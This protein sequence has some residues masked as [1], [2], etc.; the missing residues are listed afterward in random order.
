MVR[1]E[2]RVYAPGNRLS[3]TSLRAD[4]EALDLYMGRLEK[5]EGAEAIRLRWYGGMGVKQIFVS[6]NDFS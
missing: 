2:R 3:E 6:P 5:R 1:S 4:N